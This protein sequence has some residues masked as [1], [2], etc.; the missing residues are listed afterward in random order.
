MGMGLGL[1]LLVIIGL[2]PA[3]ASAISWGGREKRRGQRR[4]RGEGSVRD[5]PADPERRSAHDGQRRPAGERHGTP[6]A[7][8]RRHG[9][10][11]QHH[12]APRY[13]AKAM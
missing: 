10:L 11:P 5:G 12:E 6:P 2:P 8:L 4:R 9:L 3:T 13:V 1:I 7:H